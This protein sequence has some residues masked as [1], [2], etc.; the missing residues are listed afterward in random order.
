MYSSYYLIDIYIYICPT[1][2]QYFHTILY[3][4]QFLT[5]PFYFI[6]LTIPIIVTTD[7]AITILHLYLLLSFHDSYILPLLTFSA[8]FLLLLLLL[9][10]NVICQQPSQHSF[11]TLPVYLSRVGKHSHYSRRSQLGRLGQLSQ[12]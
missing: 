3:F 6:N 4:R 9:L 10:H 7:I 11:F 8:I 5:I 2:R 1:A 12:P